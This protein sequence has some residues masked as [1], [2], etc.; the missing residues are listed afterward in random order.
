MEFGAEG[1]KRSTWSPGT[2]RRRGPDPILNAF[3]TREEQKDMRGERES[4]RSVGLLVENVTNNQEKKQLVE[5][6][7]QMTQMLELAHD[8]FKFLL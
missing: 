6:N 8:N 7:A 3:E 2:C 1:K 5:V 4:P